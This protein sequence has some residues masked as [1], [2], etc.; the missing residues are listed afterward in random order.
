MIWLS[1]MAGTEEGSIYFDIRDIVLQRTT[2]G[3]K[4]LIRGLLGDGALELWGEIYLG[5]SSK[6]QILPQWTDDG[7]VESFSAAIDESL[8]KIQLLAEVE[9][10][11]AGFAIPYSQEQT[12]GYEPNVF[13][14]ENRYSC[15]A[16]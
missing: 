9:K 2:S 3:H 14:S 13:E 10:V 4:G 8:L 1:P 11:V 6:V 5:H 7:Q 12:A 16:A 15:L